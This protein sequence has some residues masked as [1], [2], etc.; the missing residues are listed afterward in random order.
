ME[1]GVWKAL[2]EGFIKEQSVPGG[3]K[4]HDDARGLDN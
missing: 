1:V 4:K 2:I 3:V